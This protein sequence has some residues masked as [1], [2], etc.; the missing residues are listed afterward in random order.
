MYLLPNLHPID[1]E[2]NMEIKKLSKK[3]NCIV[4]EN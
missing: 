1:Y 4:R 2:Q 3:E